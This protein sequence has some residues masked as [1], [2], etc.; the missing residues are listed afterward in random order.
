MSKIIGTMKAI[1]RAIRRKLKRAD[2]KAKDEAWKRSYPRQLLPSRMEVY[3]THLRFDERT[4]VRCLVCGLRSVTG[5]EGYPRELSSKVIEKLQELSFEG[6]KII[7]SNGLIQLQGTDTKEELQQASYNVNKEQ[8]SREITHKGNPNLELMMKRQDIVS[9]YKEIYYNSQRTFQSSFIIVIKGGEGEVF[10]AE[11]HI[12]SILKSELIEVQVPTGRM[13][14]M[15]LSALHLPVSESKAWVEVR[16][17]GAAALCAASNLNSRTD[18]KGL[19]FGKDLL[20]NSEVMLDL[21]TL[22][23]KQLV[24]CGSTGSGK[25]FTF[26]LLLMRLVDMCNA[27]VIYTTPKADEGTRYRSV[28]EFYQERGCIAD[29]GMNGTEYLNPLDILIDTETMGNSPYAYAKAYDLKKDTLIYGHKVWLGTGFSTNMDSYLDETLDKVYEQAHVYRD[30]PESFKNPMPLYKHL[31]AVWAL[32]AANDDLGTKA[33][34]AEAL[35]NKTYQFSETGRFS[36]YNNQTKGLNLSKD[37]IVIDLSGV[38]KTI[39]PFMSIIVNGML[40]TRFSTDVERETY[41]AVDEGAVY[42]R[43]EELCGNL[44]DTLTQ[45]RSHKFYLWIATHQPSDFKKNNVS[46]E[47]KTNTFINILLGNNIKNAIGDVKDYFSLT[48]EECDIL[49][50]CE[51]GQGLLLFKDERVPISFTPSPLEKGVIK[52]TLQAEEKAPTVSGNLVKRAYKN[53]VRDHKIIFEDWIIGDSSVLLQQGYEK[54]QVQRVDKSG[55][56]AAYI[57]QGMLLNKLINLPHLGDQTLDHFASV[58]QLAGLLISYG[59]EEIHINHNQDVDISAKING[60]NIAWEYERYNNKNLDIIVQK[61]AFAIEKYDKVWFVCSSSDEKYISK[62]V[63]EDSTLTRGAAVS[64]MLN[65]YKKVENLGK[66]IQE[67]SKIEAGLAA[68]EPIV[69]L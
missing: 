29:I 27:R 35:L 58:L 66:Q 14:E 37:V 69:A 53:L 1:P 7:L 54:H 44:L 18:D 50:N 10:R 56:I 26:L 64:E 33:K 25:T 48:D 20:T 36:R 8:I 61:K 42:L 46:E 57:P 28:A 62:A 12:I 38:P 24:M 65:A 45:G 43:D 60:E 34:T 23:S 47:F 31:R 32:D 41:L 13:R 59:F 19:Y 51:V 4:Y 52:G 6:V 22:A 68:S 15:F 49:C 2:E 9:N 5:S 63:G 67:T 11:S 16:S 30:E 40:A 55:T 39:K 3:D 17:D 21:N